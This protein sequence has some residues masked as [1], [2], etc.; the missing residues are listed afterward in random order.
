MVTISVDHLSPTVAQQWA[1]WLIQDINKVMK[2]RDVAEAH[3]S[4]EF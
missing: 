2:D 4:T 1:T 3:R